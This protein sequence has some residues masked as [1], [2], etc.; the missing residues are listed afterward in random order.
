M[1]TGRFFLCGRCRSQVTICRSCD[2][3]QRYCG[4]DCARAAR[5]ESVRE[6]ERRYQRSRRDAWLMRSGPDDIGLG[7]I[8]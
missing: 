6:A 4:Q 2:R 8:K 1:L 5:R 3:G 7:T